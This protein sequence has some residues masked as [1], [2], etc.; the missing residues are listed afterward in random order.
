MCIGL[1]LQMF[2]DVFSCTFVF[3]F[4]QPLASMLNSVFVRYLSAAS[5]YHMLSLQLE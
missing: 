1:P 4:I 2:V 5:S 3:R